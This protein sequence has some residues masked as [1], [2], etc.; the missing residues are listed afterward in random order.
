MKIAKILINFLLN[1]S[2]LGQL[3]SQFEYETEDFYESIAHLAPP[4]LVF[5]LFFFCKMFIEFLLF[6]QIYRHVFKRVVSKSS[7]RRFLQAKASS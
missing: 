5:I 2:I 1:S 3:I 4:Q 7:H 6:I